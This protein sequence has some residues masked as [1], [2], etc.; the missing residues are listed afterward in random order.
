MPAGRPLKFRTVQELEGKIQEYEEYIKEEKK[1]MTLERL[2]CFLGCS[3][4][5]LRRYGKEDKFYA[6][7]KDIRERIG[8]DK[9]ERLNTPGQPVAGI[10]FDLKNN[11]GMK[12]KTEQKI[13]HSGKVDMGDVF[14]KI[15]KK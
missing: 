5:L 10:I 14:G 12:D 7:I 13:D 8:A 3:T 1:P 2:A 9:V 11:H 4:E 15:D 6:T